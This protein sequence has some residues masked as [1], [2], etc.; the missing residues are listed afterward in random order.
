VHGKPLVYLDNAA[1]AQKPLAVIEG[2]R[3]YLSNY[4]ANIHRGAHHLAQLATEAYEGGRRKIAEHIGAPHTEGII[5]TSGSTDA[6]NLVAQAWGRTNL[7]SGD[8][9]LVTQM[10]HHANIVP[11]Q[12]VCAERGAQ[13]VPAAVLEDGTL[14]LD[15]FKRL[16]ELHQPK[17]AAF[18]HASNTLGTINPVADLCTL[19]K[20]AGATT[21]VDGSQALPHLAIDVQAIGCDFYVATGHKAYGPTGIG[22]LYGKQAQLEAMPPWRGGGEMIKSVSFDGTTFNGLPHKF[23]AGT[24]HISGGIALGIAIDWINGIG[25]PAI[26]AHEQALVQHAHAALGTLKGLRII[27]T[28]PHKVGVVSLVVDGL[29]PYDLGTLLDGQGIAV[30]T[31]HHCT[32]PLMQHLGL[33]S[34]TL[35]ISFA[36]YTTREEIDRTVIALDRAMQMLS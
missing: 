10:E 21:L 7:Q 33:E 19:A 8:T 34:G 24:P 30:R 9:V 1:S 20:A 11:W 2:Q 3:E 36:A 35:R 17:M 26:A 18:V 23:E 25:T 4:H 6:I 27:G 22:F 16:L 15:D 5:F 29:H 14:D 28:A 32:E 13:V 12:M 31:G